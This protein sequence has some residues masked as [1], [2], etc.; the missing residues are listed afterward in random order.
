VIAVEQIGWRAHAA[1]T[2]SD[3]TAR[4]LA[5][6]TGSTWLVADGDIVWL[7]RGPLHPRAVLIVDDPSGRGDDVVRIDVR[8]ARVWHPTVSAIT[9]ATAAVLVAGAYALHR[10]LH[11]IGRVDGLA[12]LV[13][14]RATAPRSDA[15]G[16][17]ADVLARSAPHVTALGAACAGDRAND[18]IAPALALLGLGAG[19]TPSG[20]DFVGG[21]FFG[22]R[23]LAAA[24]LA[25]AEGWRAAAEVVRDGARE[26]T[27][28]I[29]Q[30]LLGDL[31]DGA[32][33]APL[34]DVVDALVCGGDLR[35]RAR[36]LTR[37]GHSSGWDILAGVVV[38]LTSR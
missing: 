34:H 26:R 5:R 6:M 33:H 36:A 14:G 24:G 12:H 3:G 4:V 35:A 20:D 2:R 9:P 31:M 7:G 19:L 29:S 28:A 8:H 10:G 23:L 21:V 38:A 11:D 18:A 37:L 15:R 32:S 25:H 13:A 27:H 1:L 16:L 30:A 22:R 17:L